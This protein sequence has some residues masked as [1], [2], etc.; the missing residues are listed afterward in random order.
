MVGQWLNDTQPS[1]SPQEQ[2]A[3]GMDGGSVTLLPGSSKVPD[4]SD[5]LNDLQD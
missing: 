5:A 2:M 4:Q 1:R 3:V